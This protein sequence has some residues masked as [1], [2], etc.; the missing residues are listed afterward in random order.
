MLLQKLYVRIWLAVV[1]AVAVLTLLVGWAWRMAAEPPLR[2]VV[3]RNQAGEIIGSGVARLGHKPGTPGW[4]MAPRPPGTQ[5]PKDPAAADADGDAGEPVN[6][7]QWSDGPQFEVHMQNGQ[8]MHLH[9]PRPPQSAWRAPFGFF[10]TLGLVAVAVALATYPIVRRLTRRLEVLQRSVEQW[11][12]GNLSVRVPMGG[13]DE[14]G[15]LA[16]RFNHAAQQIETLVNA[17][18]ALL[19]SQKSLLANAS[20]ELRSP[21][22][23]IRMGLE[24]LGSTPNTQAKDEISRNIAELDQLIDEILLAS[25]LDAK[26]AD[27]GTVEVVDMVGLAAEE[28]ARTSAIL[29]ADTAGAPLLVPGVNKLLRR[30]LRNLLENAHR[31]AAG[32]VTVSLTQ[33]GQQAVIQ[34]CDHGP[35]VPAALQARIFEPFYRLPGASERDG[36]VGLGL[37]LVKSIALRHGGTVSCRNQDQGGA[38]FEIRLPMQTA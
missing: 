36:G 25:R 14:V 16:S 34:V 27:L 8:T 21:L 13:K 31:Y 7:N 3:V 23:R 26:E 5:A 4:V 37:A 18:D 17:R 30:A 11:G 33:E 28:C 6:R 24:F 9:L 35:G 12:D 10:W 19:A 20:H 38:C 2:E 22:T 32:E 29:E 15:F 1:L